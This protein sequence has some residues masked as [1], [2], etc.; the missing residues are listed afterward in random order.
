MNPEPTT[1]QPTWT[2]VDVTGAT[3]TYSGN[4]PLDAPADADYDSA[5]LVCQGN[6]HVAFRHIVSVTPLT[7]VEPNDPV[8]DLPPADMAPNPAEREG[9]GSFLGNFGEL[10]A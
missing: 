6:D 9:S 1:T 5:W 2:V 10:N 4:W 7:V 3:H 8:S